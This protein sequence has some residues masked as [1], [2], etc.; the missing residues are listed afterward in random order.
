MKYMILYELFT[1]LFHP[2]EEVIFAR[3]YHPLRW[4]VG[5]LLFTILGLIQV[6]LW[7]ITVIPA[8]VYKWIM[9]WRYV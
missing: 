2:E 4:T 5:V 6:L 3:K 7:L 1:A 9:D 8:K